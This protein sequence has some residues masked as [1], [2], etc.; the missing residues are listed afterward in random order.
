MDA[1]RLIAW[2]AGLVAAAVG[3]AVIANE[4]TLVQHLTR[5]EMPTVAAHLDALAKETKLLSEGALSL[6]MLLILSWIKLR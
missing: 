4:T 3:I 6:V 2:V 1:S 5:L